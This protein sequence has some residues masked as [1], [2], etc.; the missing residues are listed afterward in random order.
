[1][2]TG[3]VKSLHLFEARYL[4]LL[5]DVLASPGSNKC[6]GF[7][8]VEQAGDPFGDAASSFPGAYASDGYVM[9]MATL[10][11]VSR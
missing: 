8:V 2:H 9:T 1:M 10:V 7:V 5:D 11:R 6:F 3:S 4:A